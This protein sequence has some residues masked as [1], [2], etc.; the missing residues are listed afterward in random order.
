MS[1]IACGAI[2]VE[3]TP[4]EEPEHA[5]TVTVRDS[6]SAGAKLTT[7]A[8]RRKR[9]D[10]RVE[11][12]LRDLQDLHPQ[13]RCCAA[14]SSTACGTVPSCGVRQEPRP[15]SAR[16][17]A[18]AAHGAAAGARHVAPQGALASHPG[19]WLRGWTTAAT[20]PR[21]RGGRRRG[22]LPVSA[23]GAT[24]STWSTPVGPENHNEVG[25]E[26]RSGLRSR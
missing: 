4:H 9:E 25:A 19:W 16:S 2:G 26:R 18:A 11:A 1:R 7:S 15:T 13:R 24:W 5:A 6:T 12:V 17:R 3:V 8:R 21:R 23:R 20:P 22:G 10:A 14:G